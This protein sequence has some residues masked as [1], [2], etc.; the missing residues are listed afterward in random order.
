MSFYL[1][2]SDIMPPTGHVWHFLNTI[3]L[4]WYHTIGSLKLMTLYL[5]TIPFGNLHSYSTSRWLFA[6]IIP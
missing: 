5:G 2:I 3:S 1:G 6:K 4:V